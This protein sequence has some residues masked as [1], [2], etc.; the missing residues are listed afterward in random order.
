MPATLERENLT[1]NEI[2][3]SAPR[4]FLWDG[5]MYLRASEAGFF[6][7]RKVELIGGEIVEMSPHSKPHIVCANKVFEILREIFPREY[8]IVGQSTY[9]ANERSKPEPDIAVFHAS[10]N[11]LLGETPLVPVLICEVSRDTL[12][13]DRT[14]KASLYASLGVPDYWILNLIDDRIE[15]LRTP[16]AMSDQPFGFGYGSTTIFTREETVSP[17][18]ISGVQIAVSELLP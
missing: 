1:E 9:H 17:L 18:E 10:W 8:R 4:P 3:Q 12:A 16:R 15:V 6:G 7:E 11:D 2:L 5:E 13:Y 14:R